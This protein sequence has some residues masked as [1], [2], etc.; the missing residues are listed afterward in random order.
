M[1]IVIMPF[2]EECQLKKKRK[3]NRIKDAIPGN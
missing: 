3:E 2:M 1:Q